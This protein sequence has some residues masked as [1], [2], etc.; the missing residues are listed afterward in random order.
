MKKINLS[1]Y[2]L[3]AKTFWWLM[4]L[5]S[6]SFCGAAIYEVFSFSISQFVVLVV[7]FIIS[8]L[9]NQHQFTIPQ[10]K[11]TFTAKEIFFVWGTIW[12]GVPG[13]VLLAVGV[14]AA[15]YKI[16]SRDKKQWLFDG[17]VSVA[18]A[19]AA[20]NV[21]FLILKKFAGFGENAVGEHALA[22]G[23]LAIATTVMIFTHYLSTELLTSIFLKIE[24]NSSN[25]DSGKKTFV[26]SL[27]KYVTGAV[28]AFIIHLAADHAFFNDT[29]PEVYD[30]DAAKDAW[31]KVINF[32]NENL[33]AKHIE[34]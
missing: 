6:I 7:A 2:N 21:F 13:G 10:T 28:A 31:A 9:V 15:R 20:T 19:F 17:F 24:K 27:V 18:S 29:R 5:V 30:E 34:I 26:P 4:L 25:F 32:F 12:L 22:F 8:V 16:A 11:V 3:P 33:S 23:W 14:S 1:E